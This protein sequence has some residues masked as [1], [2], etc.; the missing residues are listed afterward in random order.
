MK[1]YA[2]LISPRA[3]AAFFAQT[4]DVA[5]GELRLVTGLEGTPFQ[6][7]DMHF[8]RIQATDT[9]GLA[10]LSFVQGIFEVQGDTL[11]PVPERA[12]FQLHPDFIWGEKYRGKTNETL[13]QLLI[14]LALHGREPE[15]LRLLD[16]MSGRGTT[17]LWAMRYG[18]HAVGIDQ[19]PTALPEIRRALK[20]WTKLHRQKHRL[21]EGWVQKSNKTGTGN[22]LEFETQT[23][24]RAIIGDTAKAADLVQ[25]KT[26]DLIVSDVPYGVQHQGGKD[27]RNPTDILLGAIAGWTKCLAQDGTMAIAFNSYMPKRDVLEDAFKAAGLKPLETNLSHRMSESILR[28]VIVLTK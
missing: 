16:P 2:L 3:D 11:L 4:L 17:L 25:R 14:N 7:A 20:K 12:N 22:Y 9:K 24:L 21:S 13:T 10:R 23:R 18:M 15:D 27:K 26:F 8:L 1:T 6:I 28:D 5:Q 19:D